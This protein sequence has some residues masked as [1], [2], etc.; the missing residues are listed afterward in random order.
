[1]KK[2]DEVCFF[3]KIVMDDVSL[4]RNS[5]SAVSELVNETTFEFSPEGITLESV[6]PAV[7]AMSVLKIMPTCFTQYE[8]SSDVKI[9]FNINYFLDVIKR[10]RKSDKV[11]IELEEDEGRLKI[12]MK[13]NTK[14]EFTVSLIE[15]PEKEQKTPSPE[16]EG[17]I[18]IGNNVLS[19]AVNDCQMVSDC[20][21]FE[22][23]ADKLI[24][25]ASG[26]LN[27][28]RQELTKDSPS[29]KNISFKEKQESKY[30]LEYLE[31]ISKGSSIA[32][33]TTIRF[34]TNYLLEIEYLKKDKLKLKFL[35]APRVDN[36]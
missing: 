7:V 34:K 13:G 36:E 3:M 10:A 22:A 26:D 29:L 27:T 12:I 20:A 9:T 32:D 1:M 17:E 28:V 18:E 19:D 21:V 30:S 4:F 35:L 5:L 11:I 24:I 14:K 31:K 33:T 23:D 15:N 2:I 8:V 6:D 16:F 25:S